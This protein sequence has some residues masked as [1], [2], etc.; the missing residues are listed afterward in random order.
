MPEL[1]VGTKDGVED[2]QAKVMSC[3]VVNA[4]VISKR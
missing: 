3:V 2:L 4:L 1:Q